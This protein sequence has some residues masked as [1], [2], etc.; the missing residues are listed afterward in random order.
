MILEVRDPSGTVVYKAPEPEPT[1]GDQ[2][3]RRPSS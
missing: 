3:R 2:R 1:H